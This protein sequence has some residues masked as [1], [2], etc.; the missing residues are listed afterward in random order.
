[1]N[2]KLM[3]ALES[4][5]IPVFS[6]ASSFAFEEVLDWE[7]DDMSLFISFIKKL[8]ITHLYHFKAF[9]ENILDDEA[10]LFELNNRLH[11]FIPKEVKEA[12]IKYTNRTGQDQTFDLN[13]VHREELLNMPELED[14]QTNLDRRRN[15]SDILQDGDDKLSPEEER[16]V[17]Q[18]LKRDIEEIVSEI[19]APIKDITCLEDLPTYDHVVEDYLEKIGCSFI[20]PKI[21]FNFYRMDNNSKIDSVSSKI[22]ELESRLEYILDEKNLELQ[23][24]LVNNDAF[25]ENLVG[26]FKS[27]KLLKAKKKNIQEYLKREGIVTEKISETT[28]DS[29]ISSVNLVLTQK[30][31]K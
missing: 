1:M 30:Q 13:R 15:H 24:A 26:N 23:K 21:K 28:Y 2:T 31:G 6:T 18:F 5:D 12:K 17:K 11:R 20:L 25:I 3:K 22:A 8:K 29:I 4:I 10:I 19:A 9:N 7:G 16:S 27:M 14:A